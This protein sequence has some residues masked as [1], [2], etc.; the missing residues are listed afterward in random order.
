M[1]R[2]RLQEGKIISGE[3]TVELLK[4]AYL[5][6]SANIFVVDGFPRLLEQGL[7]FEKEITHCEFTLYFDAPKEVL[8]ERL[9]F[10]EKENL[11]KGQIRNDDNQLSREKVTTAHS[12]LINFFYISYLFFL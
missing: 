1:I 9:I 8:E 7:L 2:T 10:R 11:K 12:H 4:S 6:S 5:N 3:I